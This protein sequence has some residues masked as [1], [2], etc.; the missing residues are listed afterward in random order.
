MRE[1][2]DIESLLI[3][4]SRVP[5]SI[6]YIVIA[7]ADEFELRYKYDEHCMMTTQDDHHTE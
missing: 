3:Q 1:E 2:E 7:S 6:L 4:R 5:L